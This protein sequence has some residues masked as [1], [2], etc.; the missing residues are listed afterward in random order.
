MEVFYI[1]CIFII[2]LFFGS[3]FCCVGL[4][5]ARGESFIRG[6]S[7]CDYCKEQLK[8][9]DLIPLVS[10]LT[11]KGRCRYCK[12]K[13]SPLSFFIELFTASLFA[14]SYYSF[15]FS[16]DFVLALLLISMAMIIFSSDL[17]YLIIPDEIIIFFGIAIIIVQFLRLSFFNTLIA[18]LSG[19]VF[20]FFM[21]VLM[22]LGNAIF[23]KESLGGGDVKLAFILG[24]VLEPFLALITIFLASLI[25]LP[26]SLYLLFKN[27]EHVIPFGPFMLIGF[28]IV[29]FMKITTSDIFTFLS[30]ISLL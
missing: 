7:K 6:H 25:A 29:F 10:Y 16:L 17:T 18:I 14:L 30:N 9:K 19:L 5:L 27:K 15:G 4:R 24:L 21:F 12:E 2:G 22:Q 20:F 8:V 23:K 3:F 13:I 11:L 26:I 1:V 28:F